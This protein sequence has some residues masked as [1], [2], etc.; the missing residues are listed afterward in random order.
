MSQALERRSPSDLLDP[1]DTLDGFY[2]RTTSTETRRVYRRVVEEFWGF[3]QSIHPEMTDLRFACQQIGS[4][5]VQA[6]RDWLMTTHS[7]KGKKRRPATVARAL[8]VVKALFD[9]LGVAP[10]PASP[11]RV[12]RP[13]V[14]NVRTDFL[15]PK[16]I[17]YVL[18]GPDQSKTIGARDYAILKMFFRMIPRRGELARLQVKDIYGAK[19]KWRVRF[20]LKGG[21]EF[22]KPMPDD[23]KESIDA[24]L[25]LDKHRRHLLKSD[26][27]DAPLFQPTINNRKGDFNKGL[28]GSMIY[29]IFHRWVTYAGFET[30]AYPHAARGSW[31]TEGLRRGIPVNKLRLGGGWKSDTMIWRYNKAGDDVEQNAISAFNVEEEEGN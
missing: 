10:N 25:A 24:Y 19:G 12:Q 23:V 17:K 1:R 18:A 22:V 7:Q 20:I 5:D 26:G 6:Y 28:D 4:G 8:H 29:M 31:V 13:I 11:A 3:I 21:R 27:P 9:H 16:Q 30:G 15:R 2:F 14:N